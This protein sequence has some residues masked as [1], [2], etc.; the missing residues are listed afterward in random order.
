LVSMTALPAG[1]ETETAAQFVTSDAGR[2]QAVHSD[3]AMKA[4][5]YGHRDAPCG[6]VRS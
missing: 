4:A 2:A 3:T 1:V 5:A 6:V